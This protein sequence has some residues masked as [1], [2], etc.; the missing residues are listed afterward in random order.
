MPRWN[1]ESD[2]PKRW[3]NEK[4]F[5][6]LETHITWEDPSAA[7]KIM[8]IMW[9]RY[10]D[11]A[12]AT[13]RSR[14]RPITSD[15]PRSVARREQRHARRERGEDYEHELNQLAKNKEVGNDVGVDPG[16][17]VDTSKDSD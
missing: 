2:D 1:D 15:N 6:E 17:S 10:V 13:K 16:W 4:L 7:F 5:T 11:K 8:A 12:P 9:A 3:S 14:G